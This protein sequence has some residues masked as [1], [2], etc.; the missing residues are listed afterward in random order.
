MSKNRRGGGEGISWG[1]GSRQE[2]VIQGLLVT[3]KS[4]TFVLEMES[5]LSVLSTGVTQ[6]DLGF[7]RISLATILEIDQS[8]ARAGARRP[9]QCSRW[10]S[11]GLGGRSDRV[12]VIRCRQ[13]NPPDSEGPSTPQNY[14]WDGTHPLRPLWSHKR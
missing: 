7:N 10:K 3:A 11:E 6:S 13:Q 14:C 5:N 8:E 4:L 12:R 2:K 9:L 1:Q